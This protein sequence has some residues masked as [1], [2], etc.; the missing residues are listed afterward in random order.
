MPVIIHSLSPLHKWCIYSLSRLIAY[1]VHLL[2]V[3]LITFNCIHGT[4]THHHPLVTHMANLEASRVY[5]EFIIDHVHISHGKCSLM[6]P[7]TLDV[8]QLWHYRYMHA[9]GWACEQSSE[10]WHLLS[11]FETSSMGCRNTGASS[12]LTVP[13]CST[14]DK[15]LHS[16]S[17]FARLSSSSCKWR[18]KLM[19][20]RLE[21]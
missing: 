13:L 7:A 12:T 20:A 17:F 1:M 21:S 11:N 19:L 9:P 6:Q 2:I 8:N 14:L 10:G 5:W 15:V 18:K 3:R 4:F 16:S